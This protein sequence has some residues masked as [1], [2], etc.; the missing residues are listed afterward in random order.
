MPKKRATRKWR[1]ITYRTEPV[2]VRLVREMATRLTGQRIVVFVPKAGRYQRAWLLWVSQTDD[3]F[4]VR[5]S[6]GGFTRICRGIWRVHNAKLFSTQGLPLVMYPAMI[7]SV[8][9]PNALKEGNSMATRSTKAASKGRTS[10]SKAS[11]NGADTPARAR[12][13]LEEYSEAE[14]KRLAKAI[15]KM[16]K[17]GAKWGEIGEELDLP[18]ERPSV[19]GRRL[20]REYHPDGEAFIQERAPR[21]EAPAA[22]RSSRRKAAEVDD[23]ESDDGEEEAPRTRRASTRKRTTV[24]TGRGRKTNP[25]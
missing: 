12:D 15:A 14:R 16:K 24:K 13:I 3:E 9:F 10:K 6:K 17:D 25:S 19:A 2:D 23:D 21:E 1:Q 8:T 11:S 5:W 18:G 20:L 7:D 22:K 4:L